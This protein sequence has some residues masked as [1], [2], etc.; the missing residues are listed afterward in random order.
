MS[1]QEYKTIIV[2]CKR[3]AQEFEL[4]LP[5][6]YYETMVAIAEEDGETVEFTGTC[7]NCRA[8]DPFLRSL[9]TRRTAPT[10]GRD[11]SRKLSNK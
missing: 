10:I 2:P 9:W 7:T 8:D 11:F 4:R 1:E 3:C 6:H 5:M